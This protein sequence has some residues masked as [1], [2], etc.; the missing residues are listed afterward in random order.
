MA[1]SSARNSRTDLAR[2]NTTGGDHSPRLLIVEDE[3]TLRAQVVDSVHAAGYVADEADNGLDALHQGMPN[4]TTPWS[5]TW[6]C[7]RW[8]ACPGA[9]QMA[10]GWPCDAGADPDCT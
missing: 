8:M 9:A 7:P 1:P 5:W 6:G 4:L 3:P 10:G 2:Q